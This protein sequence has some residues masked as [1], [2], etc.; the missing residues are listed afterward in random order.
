[1][2]RLGCWSKLPSPHKLLPRDCSKQGS[3]AVAQLLELPCHL[4]LSLNI[5]NL[6]LIVYILWARRQGHRH[7]LAVFVYTRTRWFN[8]VLLSV[9]DKVHLA[10]PVCS[11][12]T[13]GLV[14]PVSKMEVVVDPNR[15][16]GAVR[17][18]PAARDHGISS[19][20][21]WSCSVENFGVLEVVELL[22][23][24]HGHAALEHV[25]AFGLIKSVSLLNG[26]SFSVTQHSV[27]L[28]LQSISLLSLAHELVVSYVLRF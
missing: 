18:V 1:M 24:A 23:T 19:L 15:S 5:L 13:S 8:G 2:C 28:R 21:I 17:R 7:F 3:V 20:Q 25:K 9:L 12:V 26:S 27:G 10:N 6:S 4:F 16:G 11:L 22:L 14:V